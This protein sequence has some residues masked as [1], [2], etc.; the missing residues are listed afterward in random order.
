MTARS[1]VFPWPAVEWVAVCLGTDDQR[2]S[3]RARDDAVDE[4][5][6]DRA[7]GARPD[8]EFLALPHRFCLKRDL[9]DGCLHGCN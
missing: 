4:R 5:D 1:A 9:K 6:L 8:K 2:Q 7:V 3:E